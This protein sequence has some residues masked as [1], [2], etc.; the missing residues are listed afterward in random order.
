VQ[1]VTLDSSVIIS[2]LISGGEPLRLLQMAESRLIG[3]D[4]SDSIYEEFGRVL[5]DRFKWPPGYVAA[6]QQDMSGF[7][8]HVTPTETVAVVPDDPNDDHVVACAAGARSD[9]LI[10]GDKH[11]LKLGSFRGTRIIKVA[12]FLPWGEGDGASSVPFREAV[13]VPT[14]TGVTSVDLIRGYSVPSMCPFNAGSSGS[15]VRSGS[16]PSFLVLWLG[17]FPQSW[18]ACNLKVTMDL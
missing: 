14:A 9:Y 17:F 15:S 6:I 18:T 16:C 4:I 8:N 13:G 10:S 7:A 11:L 12:D 3:L 1:S 2:A 5:R